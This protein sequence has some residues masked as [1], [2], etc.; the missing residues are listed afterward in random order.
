MAEAGAKGDVKAV[1]QS[2]KDLRESQKPLLSKA[3]STAAALPSHNNKKDKI[4]DALKELDA[5]F[6]Q[7]EEAARDLARNPQDKGKRSKLDE[8]NRR[9]AND[10]DELSSML[11]DVD[12]EGTSFYIL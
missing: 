12:N 3:R 9:I 1:D 6:P 10:L 8:L 7:Q 5:L 2:I 11:A 4:L